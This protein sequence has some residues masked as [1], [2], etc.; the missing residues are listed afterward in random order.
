MGH[1]AP[2]LEDVSPRAVGVCKVL[3]KNQLRKR[4]LAISLRLV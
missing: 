1:V 3:K 2:K 4:C